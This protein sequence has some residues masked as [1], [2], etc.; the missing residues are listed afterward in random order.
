MPK[1]FFLSREPATERERKKSG[2][3]FVNTKILR[4]NR[5]QEK[6]DALIYFSLKVPVIFGQKMDLKI[7]DVCKYTIMNHH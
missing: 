3:I 1:V 4:S 7:V 2:Y 5:A 6:F